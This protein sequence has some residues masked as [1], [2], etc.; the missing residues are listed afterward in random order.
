[1]KRRNLLGGIAALPLMTLTLGV[2]ALAADQALI[3][4]AKSEGTVVWYSGYLENQLLVPVAKAF[5][6]KYGIK[7]EYA[8]MNSADIILRMTNEKQADKLS[9]DVF[10]GSNLLPL[11]EAGMAAS[12]IPEDA[13]A[14]AEGLVAKDGTWVAPNSNYLTVGYNTSMVSTDEAPKTP[15]DLLDPRWKDRMAISDSPNPTAG[16]GF[17]GAVLKTKGEEAGMEYLR[18]LAAQNV[19]IIPA[20]QKVVLDN[21]ISGEFE[22]GL[23]TFNHHSVI[24]QAKGAPVDWVRFDPVIASHTYVSAVEGGPHPNAGK[25]LVD[26]LMS[27]EGQQALAAADYIPNHPNVDAQTPELKPSVGGFNVYAVTVDDLENDFDHWREIFK[28]L[29][30]A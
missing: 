12:F 27:E 21:V 3:D 19:T 29:F 9:V 11:Y 18:A 22:L 28:D 23:M 17:V 10:D 8:R 25:L 7:V 2:P 26:Y 16:P 13:A 20:N 30:G 15:D 24:G 6:D 14:Y 1:M 5:E 4:A